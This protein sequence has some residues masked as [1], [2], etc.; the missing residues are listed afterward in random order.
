MTQPAVPNPNLGA[1]ATFPGLL[2]ALTAFHALG[3][4]ACFVMA[5][6]SALSA[7][8]RDGLAMSGSSRIMVSTFGYLTPVFLAFV[9]VILTILAR[10]SWKKRWWAWHLTIAVYSIGV[11]GSLWQVSVGIHEGWLAT[12]V[13]GTVVI[14][15]SR[16]SVRRAYARNRR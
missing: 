9:G 10:A 6:G 4:L 5:A 1:T 15:A 14:Y 2:H 3:A 8:F 12:I 16:P 13:N 11:L 7:D